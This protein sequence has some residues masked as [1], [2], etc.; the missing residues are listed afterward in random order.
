MS[1]T[2]QAERRQF[3]L[4]IRMSTD[5]LDAAARLADAQIDVQLPAATDAPLRL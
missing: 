1:Q 4:A 3:K 5:M 2:Y